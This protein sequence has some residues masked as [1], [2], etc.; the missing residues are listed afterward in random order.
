MAL[1]DPGDIVLVP[2]PC[3][4]AYLPGILMVARKC[5]HALLEENDFLPDLDAIPEGSAARQ[6]DA[7]QFPGQSHGALG[8]LRFSKTWWSSPGNTTSSSPDAPYSKRFS[9]GTASFVPRNSGAKEVGIEF[10]SVSKVFNMSGWRCAHAV[11]NAE[12][13]LVWAKCAP[14]WTWVFFSRFSMPPSP[15]D[16]LHGFH[17]R[18]VPGL[19]PPPGCADRRFEPPGLEG[20]QKSRDV[21]RLDAGSARESLGRF[22]FRRVEK[23]GVLFTPGRGFGEYGEGYIRIALTV[24]RKTCAKPWTASKKRDSCMREVLL[25]IKGSVG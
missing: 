4:T 10:H 7:A 17:P 24:E 3:Y 11:G 15:P 5:I 20:P 1:C 22:R 23:S 2:N 14:M 6:T 9:I 19:Q 25:S 12:S 18:D 16:R 8:P 13:W 21:L